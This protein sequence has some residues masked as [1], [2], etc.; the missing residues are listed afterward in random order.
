MR[1]TVLGTVLLLTGCMTAT[2]EEQTKAVRNLP[3][4]YRAQ[5]KAKIKTVLYDPY[6]IRD[7]EISGPT[8]IFSGLIEGNGGQLPGVCIR[9]NAKN[10]Y[11][12]YVGIRTYAVSFK[13]G[14]AYHAQP[15][16]YNN[17]N[18]VSWHPFPD[19]ASSG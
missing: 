17:C 2:P 6:S 3:A 18:G 4:D 9:F 14:K 13:D 10:A 7:A 12:A 19:L 1:N 16:F 15:P 8:A 5:I 11:G